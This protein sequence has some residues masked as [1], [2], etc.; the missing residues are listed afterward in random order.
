[1]NFGDLKALSLAYVPQGKASAISVATRGSLL[2]LAVADIA[3]RAKCV[4]TYEDFNS[5]ASTAKYNL[6]SNLTRYIALDEGGVW[7]YDG[8]DWKQKQRIN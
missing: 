1:M 3:A 2:N 4:R 5:S 7:F 8:T 6:G